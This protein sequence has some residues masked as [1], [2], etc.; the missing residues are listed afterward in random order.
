MLEIKVKKIREDAVLPAYQT[1]HSAGLDLYACIEE[2]I[3]INPKEIKLIPTGISIEL[4]DGY[5]AQ[6]RPR[7]GLAVKYGI[8]VLNTPGTI[9]PDYRGE[10]MVIII[11]LGEK[12]FK[13][14]K[15]SRIAQMIITKF[16]RVNLKLTDILTPT[17]RNNNGFGSTGF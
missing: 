4:P 14:T 11:N 15:N 3:I 12:P 13:I 5:E 6:I 2:D 1:E 9:D 8:T 17:K 10:I 16:E 7:S